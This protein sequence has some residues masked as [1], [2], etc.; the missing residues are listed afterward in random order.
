MVAGAA[1]DDAVL[2]LLLR[3]LGDAVVRAAKLE[4][5]DRLSVFALQPDVGAQFG[6]EAGRV[7]DA[8]LDGDVVNPCKEDLD[9][10]NGV[11]GRTTHSKEVT[12]LARPNQEERG[13]RRATWTALA[14]GKTE[15][16]REARHNCTPNQNSVLTRRK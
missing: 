14:N 1:C 11:K 15:W 6:R 7:V 12:A 8:R 2:L 10:G 16:R 5:K 4:R 9:G 3:E 13:V